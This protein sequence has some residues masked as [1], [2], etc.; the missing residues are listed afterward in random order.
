M[1]KLLFII[2]LGIFYVGFMQPQNGQPVAT[3]TA[4]HAIEASR[5][6]DQIIA[7]A[8][9]RQQSSIPVEGRGTVEKILKDDADG[10]RHQR[11]ILRLANG[12]SLLVAHNTE[13]APRIA[14]LQVGDAV[15]FGGEYEW[16]PKGGVLHW[17]HH[18]PRNAHLNGWLSHHGN[19]YQ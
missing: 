15:E 12:H 1:I 5:N 18:D 8:F 2:L 14:D 16:N 11:F 4:S 13:L 6:G 9:A 19:T 3:Q 7:D 10:H 17:T